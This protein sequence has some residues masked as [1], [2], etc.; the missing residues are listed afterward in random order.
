MGTDGNG[1]AIESIANGEMAGTAAQ[2]P[3]EI[4]AICL[5][6]LV[7]VIKSGEIGDV[8]MEPETE[9]LD[10]FI[11]SPENVSEHRN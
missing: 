3:G 7:D 1:E 4:G 6:M 9:L 5:R 8:N 10:S 11:I 2:R